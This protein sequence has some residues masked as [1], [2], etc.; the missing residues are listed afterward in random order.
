MKQQSKLLKV[1][2]I[3]MIIFGILGTIGTFI[4]A[5]LMQ[6]VM[7]SPEMQAAYEAA[8]VPQIST[9]YYVVGILVAVVEVVAGIVGLMYRSKKSVLIAGIIWTVLILINMIWGMT[10]VGF[11]FTS[12]FS[13]VFP[14]LYFW[15]WYK[16]N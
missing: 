3:L 15:G 11:Q 5:F 1:M 8:G 9:A 4:S 14:V 13:L 2:S 16:S 7:Q 12:I 6:T 10:I